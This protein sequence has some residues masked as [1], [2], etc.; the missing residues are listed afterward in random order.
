MGEILANSL[1][2]LLPK[3]G[4]LEFITETVIVGFESIK[5]DLY[6]LLINLGLK[7]RVSVLGILMALVF[8]VIGRFL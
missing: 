7:L 4:A 8:I 6:F 3:S 2:T 5:L 1:H